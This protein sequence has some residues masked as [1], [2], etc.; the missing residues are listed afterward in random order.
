MKSHKFKGIIFLLIVVIA[1]G[2][3]KIYFEKKIEPV[4]ESSDTLVMV[5]IP[6]GASTKQIANILYEK[7]VIKSELAFRILS[8]MSKSDG[9]MQAGNY[10]FKQ[11]MSVDEIIKSLISGDTVKDTVKV[12]IPEGF[13]F[14]QIVKRLEEK[15][16]INKDKFIKI[17]NNEDFDYKFLKDIPKGKNRL[18]GFLFPDTYEI[19]KNDTEREIIIKMLNR[20]DDIFEDAYYKRA[21][22]LNMSVNDIITLASIIEREAKVDKERPIVSSVF[23]NRIRK[24]MPLQSCATVQYVLGERKAKLSFKDVETDSPYN[25]Y[26]H[27]GLPPRPIA[28][29]GKASIEAALYPSETDYLYFVVSKNGEHHFSKTFKEHL[30]AKNGI[31]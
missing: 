12:T 19:A 13:E 21:K 22:E 25:T 2:V 17:A 8:K 31:Y 20:F 10:S 24:K 6:I 26:K 7:H 23:H 5:Q 4:N 1:L 3:G 27:A 16:L 9:K 18:E 11:S 28:S 14:K 30:N 15:G 29:P